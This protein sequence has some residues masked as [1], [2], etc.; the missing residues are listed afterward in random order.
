MKEKLYAYYRVS[1]ED[2]GVRIMICSQNPLDYPTLV[3]YGV[4]TKDLE[5]PSFF[6]SLKNWL[7]AA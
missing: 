6:R 1:K 3:D 2:P 5:R 7:K 4:M